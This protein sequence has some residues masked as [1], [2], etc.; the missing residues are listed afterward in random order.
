MEGT[1]NCL[2]VIYIYSF[3]LF[4]TVCISNTQLKFILDNVKTNGVWMTLTVMDQNGDLCEIKCTRANEVA[5]ID[6]GGNC[7]FTANNNNLGSCFVFLKKTF[8]F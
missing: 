1:L 2:Q 5:I 6:H 7:L 3:S 8:K 4:R